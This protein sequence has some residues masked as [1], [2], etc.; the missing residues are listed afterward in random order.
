VLRRPPDWRPGLDVV[1]YWWPAERAWEP[2]AELTDF[3]DAGPPPVFVSFGSM[4]GGHGA[5]LA[6]I[7]TAALRDAGVRGIVQAGRAELRID[8]PDVLAV[9]EVPH[10]W[11]FPRVAAV[12]HHAGAGTTAATLRAGVPS[13]PAPVFA[14]QPLW[15]RRLVERGCAPAVLPFRRMD[16]PRLAAAVR[17]AVGDPRYRDAAEV[18]SAAVRADDGTAAVVALVQ[19]FAEG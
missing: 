10:E 7:V 8:A 15:S 2:P 9:G 5:R 18:V 3:L 6:P 4:A 17:A 16:A 14:D 13:V 11:L 1:G 19:R 12:V